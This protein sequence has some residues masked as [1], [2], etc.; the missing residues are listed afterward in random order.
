MTEGIWAGIS[1]TILLGLLAAYTIILLAEAEKFAVKRS[2]TPSQRL[3]YPEVARALFPGL[4]FFGFNILEVAVY[5]GMVL[6]SVGVCAIYGVFILGNIPSINSDIQ[7]W[8]V[9][10]CMLIL[11]LE[12]VRNSFLYWFFTK[13]SLQA[14][15]D[16]LCCTHAWSRPGADLRL[17][18]NNQRAG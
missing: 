12:G 8:Y 4:T 10:A 14:R 3:T 13:K 6:A 18:S 16:R 5:S 15:R 2:T 1:G 11:I 7:M 9:R 17:A